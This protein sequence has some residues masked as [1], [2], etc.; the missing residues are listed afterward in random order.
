MHEPTPPRTSLV[1]LPTLKSLRAYYAAPVDP[2]TSLFLVLPLFLTYHLGVLSQVRY[3]PTGYVWVGNGVDFLTGTA[4]TLSHGNPAVY[5]TGTIV[6]TLCLLAMILWARRRNELHPKLFAPV[7][8]ESGI[9][10]VFIAGGFGI[11]LERFGFGPTMP[12]G[13]LSQVIASCGAGLHE[14][15]VFRVGLFGGITYLLERRANRWLAVMGSALVTAFLFSLVHYIG[16]L[17][18]RFSV[19]SFMFRLLGGLAF[20]AIYRTRGFA[21]AAWTHCLYDILY[22]TLKRL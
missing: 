5:A 14:E 22:F 7:L 20:T 6:V 16:P 9:Y 4:L 15:L 17:G 18:D 8:L 13:F 19:D 1:P 3:T 11:L 2:L 12:T 21:I 10:A